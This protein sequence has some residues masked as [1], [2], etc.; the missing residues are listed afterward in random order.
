VAP[1]ILQVDFVSTSYAQYKKLIVHNFQNDVNQI[2]K[3]YYLKT[4]I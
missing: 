1:L 4:I 2:G 3:N